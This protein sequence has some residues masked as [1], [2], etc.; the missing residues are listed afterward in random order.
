MATAM[1]SLS[2]RISCRFLVPRMF[3]SEV[4]ANSL[5]RSLRPNSGGTS[6]LVEW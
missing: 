3:L 1:L 5:G 4:W 6:Y 2:E